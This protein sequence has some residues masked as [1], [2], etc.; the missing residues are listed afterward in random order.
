[1]QKFEANIRSWTSEPSPAAIGCRTECAQEQ[2]RGQREQEQQRNRGRFSR[3]LPESA[4]QLLSL[5]QELGGQ[6]G[7]FGEWLQIAYEVNEDFEVPFS[8]VVRDICEAF[9]IVEQNYGTAVAQY[10]Y[11]TRSA[12]LPAEIKNAARYLSCGGRTEDISALA[13]SGF[14]MEEL[15]HDTIVRA[16][17]YMEAGG[18]ASG[19]YQ[20][21]KDDVQPG[22][23]APKQQF[24]QTMGR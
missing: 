14:F 19:A 1:M 23:E 21:A 12:V 6:A 20:A 4:R 17:A 5:E 3:E 11:N 15:A 7:N 18:A 9:Q 8:D 16:V 24:Q 13:K 22:G 2:D 10:L